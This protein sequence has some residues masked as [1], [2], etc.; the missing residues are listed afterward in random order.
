MK[1]AVT[2]TLPP[3]L[4]DIAGAVEF[5]LHAATLHEAMEELYRR[6]PPLRGHLCDERGRFRGHVLCLVN[7]VNLRDLK[8]A[9]PPLAPGDR[10][11]I[12]QAISG[13]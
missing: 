7:G 6:V 12:L 1:P 8:P 9:D 4:R 13:G 10:I 2:L 5:R 11:S 3:L